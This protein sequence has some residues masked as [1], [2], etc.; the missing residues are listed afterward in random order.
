MISK[1][2]ANRYLEPKVC[3]TYQLRSPTLAMHVLP[4]Q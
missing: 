1:R 3:L 4:Y 2:S